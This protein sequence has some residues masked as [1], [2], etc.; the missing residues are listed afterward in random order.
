MKKS[1]VALI[2]VV[3]V[4]LLAA[5]GLRRYSQ[6]GPSID[7]SIVNQTAPAFT[8][9]A[10][11]GGEI[12]LDKYKGKLVLLN[13]WASWCPPCR[14]EIPGFIKIQ[15]KYGEKPFSFVGIA[16]EDKEAVMKYSQE[17]GINYP[18]AY[19]VDDAY[20]VASAYGNPDGGLPYSILIDK[21]QKVLEV[22]Y[23]FLS[24]ERLEDL[25]N[26]NL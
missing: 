11:S 20:K 5:Y 21:N 12:S 8:L 1:H 22:F 9:P 7:E 2:F 19:G 15:D 17:V 14:A 24:E 13:F 26:K 6:R 23:G 25:I 18:T 16:I 3:I 4:S 10:L